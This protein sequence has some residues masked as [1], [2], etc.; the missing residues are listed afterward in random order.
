MS[1]V[2][3]VLRVV[4]RAVATG[5]YEAAMVFALEEDAI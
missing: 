3:K 2:G 5:I 4:T 1:D